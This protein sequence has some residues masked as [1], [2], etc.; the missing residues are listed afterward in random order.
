[1]TCS[2]ERAPPGETLTCRSRFG[3]E[4]LNAD[5]LDSSAH[6]EDFPTRQ[7]VQP[8]HYSIADGRK[9]RPVVKC[10]GSGVPWSVRVLVGAPKQITRRAPRVGDFAGAALGGVTTDCPIHHVTGKSLRP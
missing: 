4:F 8:L 10:K 5:K 2:R 3:R 9:V 7:G 1:M 6:G